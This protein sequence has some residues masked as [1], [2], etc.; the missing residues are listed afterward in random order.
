MYDD[1]SRLHQIT[2]YLL[3]NNTLTTSLFYKRLFT[4]LL[5]C[6]NHFDQQQYHQIS[7]SSSHFEHNGR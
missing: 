5:N 6:E 3:Y 4:L 1:Y 2:S 7:L